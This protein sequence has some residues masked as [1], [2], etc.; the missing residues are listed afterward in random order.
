MLA[1][2]LKFF[3]LFIL[4]L[5][6]QYNNSLSSCSINLKRTNSVAA[7]YQLR[8]SRLLLAEVQAHPESVCELESSTPK[9]E[10]PTRQNPS[11]VVAV[12]QASPS[13]DKQ[14][15]I[16]LQDGQNLNY[17]DDSH[18]LEENKKQQILKCVQDE[19]V[20]QNQELP[21]PP[22]QEI[23]NVK[24]INTEN[25][26]EKDRKSAEKADSMKEKALSTEVTNGVECKKEVDVVL[27]K[28]KKMQQKFNDQEVVKTEVPKKK[29]DGQASREIKDS[30]KTKNN[31]VVFPAS[32]S[33]KNTTNTKT[34]IPNPIGMLDSAI[35]KM[36]FKGLRYV[37]KCDRNRNISKTKR[38]LVRVMVYGGT[39][40]LPFIIALAGLAFKAVESLH[41]V[42]IIFCCFNIIAC[43]YIFVKIVKYDLRCSGIRKPHFMDYVKT[44]IGYII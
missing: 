26:T 37:D 3:M 4:L 12:H 44:F 40:A 34:G 43:I 6:Y 17:S 15:G 25:N 14:K 10:E 38:Y 5:V 21:N 1:I 13:N 22:Q 42:M 33:M 32:D 27:E 9:N 11:N 29:D 39:F 30:M 16:S 31:N 23:T 18:I 19:K 8:T 41:W 28:I 7:T 24:M 35:E 2:L 20:T 36:I